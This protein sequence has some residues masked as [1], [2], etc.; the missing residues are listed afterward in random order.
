MISRKILDELIP[1]N[2]YNSKSILLISKK[3]CFGIINN[4]SPFW[5]E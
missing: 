5:F 1:L 4:Q 3:Y 2:Q